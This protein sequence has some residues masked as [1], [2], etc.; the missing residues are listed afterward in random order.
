M[1]SYLIAVPVQDTV[2]EFVDAFSMRECIPAVAVVFPVVLVLTTINLVVTSN[3]TCVGSELHGFLKHP[4]GT[5]KGAEARNAAF[6]GGAA[7]LVLFYLLDVRKWPTRAFLFALPCYTAA[8]ILFLGGLVFHAPQMPTIVVVLGILL[9]CSSVRLLRVWP[10]GNTS[11]E[12][13][14]YAVSAAFL[15]VSGITGIAWVLWAFTPLLGGFNAKWTVEYDD[16]IEVTFLLWCSPVICSLAFII[17]SVFAWTRSRHFARIPSGR[18]A[19]EQVQ[20]SRSLKATIPVLV[21]A[22]L[23]AW[24]AA[25]L[26]VED[27]A[28]SKIVLQLSAVVF[29]CIPVYILDWIGIEK[30][31]MAAKKDATVQTMLSLVF[32]DWAKGAFMLVGWPFLPLYFVIEVLHQRV[33]ACTRAC[34]LVPKKSE[35]NKWITKEASKLWTNMMSWEWTSILVKSMYCGLG[36]VCVQV[37]VSQ[38][39]VVFLAWFNEYLASWTLAAALGLLFIVEILL[40]LFPPVSGIPL[41][42]VAGIVIIPKLSDAGQTFPIG[43]A[44]TT[45]F[46]LVLKLTAIALEQKAIGHP[47]S[48]SVRVKKFVGVHTPAMKAVR[49]ILSE[50]GLSCAKIAVLCGGPD[51]PTSVITGIL[52]L[53]LCAMLCGSLPIFF[54]ILPCGFAAGSLLR[55]GEGLEGRARHEAIANVSLALSGILQGGASILAT[56]YIQA[57]V[58]AHRA[59]IEAEG[60]T[61]MR[62]AQESEILDAVKADA[63]EAEDFAK[64]TSFVVQPYAIRAV[65]ILGSLLS[66]T[67]VF[68][69]L[70]PVSPPFSEF[71]LTDKVSELPGGTALALVQPSGWCILGLAGAQLGCLALFQIA[72][73][74]RLRASVKSSAKKPLLSWAR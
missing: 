20:V 50:P 33:R 31:K 61:W 66:C 39:L 34:R 37:G 59:D 60:S 56:Y 54:L 17:V 45:L 36:L 49:A 38:G 14:S 5:F 28:L 69:L 57:V 21:A 62:D 1:C 51:W 71:V 35:D 16:P 40:F 43:I 42:M 22:V 64:R 73:T 25:S 24:I 12:A 8:G 15:M 9:T 13:F 46:C 48:S 65:L 27:F 26:A 67:S 6:A 4:T 44:A 47:F 55:A 53:P 19:D 30:I 10:F 7:L 3:F 68:V 32:G 72:C 41:Y 23:S 11:D 29:V 70:N 2:R 52:S 74:C 18:D 63:V 58:S